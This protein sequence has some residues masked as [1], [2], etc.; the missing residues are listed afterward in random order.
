MFTAPDA[1]WGFS[2]VATEDEDKAKTVFA[3][4]LGFS[5]YRGFPFDVRNAHASFQRVLDVITLEF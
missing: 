2:Q 3:I 1:L 5:C 4:N